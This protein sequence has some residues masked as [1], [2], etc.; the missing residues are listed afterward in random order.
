MNRLFHTWMLVCINLSHTY[1]CIPT[2]V[3]TCMHTDIRVFYSFPFMTVFNLIVNV[4]K[5]LNC[6]NGNL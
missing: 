1:I 5:E 6:P 3:H 2:Y 4:H